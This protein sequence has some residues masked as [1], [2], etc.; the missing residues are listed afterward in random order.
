VRKCGL[1]SGVRMESGR[2]GATEEAMR[3]TSVQR[4]ASPGPPILKATA[5]PIS[6]VAIGFRQAVGPLAM[7]RSLLSSHQMIA[8]KS[9]LEYQMTTPCIF[10]TALGLQKIGLKLSVDGF[11][12]KHNTT[13]TKA[14]VLYQI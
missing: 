9:A 7:P 2:A 4:R 11:Y 1:G 13:S 10:D 12:G 8:W 14:A 6:T 3:C 5:S